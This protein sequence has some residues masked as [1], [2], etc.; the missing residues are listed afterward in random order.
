MAGAGRSNQQDGRSV[1]RRVSRISPRTGGVIAQWNTNQHD[2]WCANRI[3]NRIDNRSGSG[4]L[5]VLNAK[6]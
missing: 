1:N 2:N 6:E 3:E 4:A 5:Q